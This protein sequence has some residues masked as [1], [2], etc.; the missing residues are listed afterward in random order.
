VVLKYSPAISE[1]VVHSSQDIQ[2]G[3]L[4]AQE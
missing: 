3:Q 4:S 2:R 1:M